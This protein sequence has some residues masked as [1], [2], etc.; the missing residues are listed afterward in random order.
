M[1]SNGLVPSSWGPP[2]W[3]S[4][5]SI[6]MSYPETVENNIEGYQ[7]KQSFYN[8][9][10]DLENILP[11]K[12]CKEHYKKNFKNM[13]L[14]YSL[15]SRKEL[16]KWIYNLHNRVNEQL[17]VPRSSWPSFEE[18]YNKYENLRAENC[19][20]NKGSQGSQGLPGTCSSGSNQEMVCKLELVPKVAVEN[21][22]NDTESPSSY[23]LS[24]NDKQWWIL[25]LVIGII[26][27]FL[28]SYMF[29]CN[30]SNRSNSSKKTRKKTTKRR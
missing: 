11:C 29:Y 28:L 14:E 4:L 26:I 24:G 13:N 21:F 23:D 10:K 22:G 1:S 2:L 6:A 8:F 18:V 5:H 25:G 17:K 19:K 20:K 12:Y 16:S 27:L 15:G 9:F 7:V 30:N 3:F